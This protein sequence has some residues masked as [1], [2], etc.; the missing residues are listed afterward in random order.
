MGENCENMPVEL[1][2]VFKVLCPVATLD[3]FDH[4]GFEELPEQ[5][6]RLVT[7]HLRP[8]VV[9]APQELVQV[10]HS[11]GAGETPVV[12]SEMCPVAPQRHA[13]TEELDGFVPLC[14]RAH[15]EEVQS[16]VIPL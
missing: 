2:T 7:A 8:K 13:S 11:L 3:V 16:S 4:V 14:E 15:I 5:L 12:A 6:Q 1:S 10:V 9:V